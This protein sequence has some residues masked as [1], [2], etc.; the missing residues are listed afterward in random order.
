M[1]L[2]WSFFE[3]QS[4]FLPR[5]FTD[6]IVNKSVCLKQL[7]CLGWMLPAWNDKGSTNGKRNWKVA[8]LL[9]FFS[10]IPILPV[11]H[12]LILGNVVHDRPL[13]SLLEEINKRVLFL[14]ELTFSF[15]DLS[16]EGQHSVFFFTFMFQS[17]LMRAFRGSVYSDARGEIL[18]PSEDIRRRRRSAS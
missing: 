12:D 2:E 1:M 7:T 11:L 5:H 13:C 9:S 6:V 17:V 10:L 16:E 3:N 8:I 15:F 18:R 4:L 14:F